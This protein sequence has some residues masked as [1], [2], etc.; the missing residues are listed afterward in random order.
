MNSDFARQRKPI[1]KIKYFNTF[2][3][4]MQ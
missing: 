1:S 2:K 3:I 4:H